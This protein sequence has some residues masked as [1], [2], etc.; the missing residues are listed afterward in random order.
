MEAIESRSN[1]NI[2]GFLEKDFRIVRSSIKY[3]LKT[4]FPSR[5]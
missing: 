5:K 3:N 4:I 1:E 2:V